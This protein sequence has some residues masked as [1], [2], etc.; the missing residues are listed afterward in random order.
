LTLLSQPPEERAE[1]RL[2]V[3]RSIVEEWAQPITQA[4]ALELCG[5]VATMLIVHRAAAGALRM[6]M[7]ELVD[8]RERLGDILTDAER[9]QVHALLYAGPAN[10]DFK[11]V[12]PRV[13]AALARWWAALAE[14]GR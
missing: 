5:L 1:R 12:P 8:C 3:L 10:G 7:S 13:C 11:A 9:E 14:H 6:A 4:Q 2:L